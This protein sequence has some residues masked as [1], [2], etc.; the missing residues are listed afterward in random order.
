MVLNNQVCSNKK[1]ADDFLS[2]ITIFVTSKEP[3]NILLLQIHHFAARLAANLQ[4]KLHCSVE[5]L[6][7]IFLKTSIQHV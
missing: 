4:L 3:F 5:C 7:N 2:N 1:F 6:F